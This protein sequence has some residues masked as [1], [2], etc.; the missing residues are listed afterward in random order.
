MDKT[1]GQQM[2]FGGDYNP[3]QW[4]ENSWESDI[5]L[6][7]QAH[8][9]SAT[10]NVFSWA[11]LEPAEGQF[12]FTKL[13][14]IIKL[15]T[16]YNFKIVLATATAAL[17]AW[18]VRQYP[19]V[20][21]VN[22]NG[23]QQQHGKRHNACP[24]NPDSQRLASQLVTQLAERFA[25][26][27]NL[28]Y[29]HIS[30]E[31][32]GLCYCDNCAQA[33]RDWLQVR[34]GDIDTLNSAWNSH[35]WSHTYTDWIDILPPMR[36]TDLFSN[37]KP[38]LGGAALD[39]QRFQ[40]DSLLANYTMERDIIRQFDATTPMT[41][42]L[43]GSQKD[44][45]Y[46]KWAPEMDIISWDNYPSYDT[47]A[48]F[49]AMQHDLMFGLKQKPFLLMEQTPNQQNW[50]PFNALKKPGEV[51]M[52]SFQAIAHGANSVQFFQLKQSL[53]GAEKF[54]G[55]I[56]PHSGQTTGRI[57]KEIAQLGTDF[58]QLPASLLDT[59]KKAQVALVFDWD[60]YWG[61]ENSIGPTTKLDY[62]QMV[63]R[64]YALFYQAGIAVDLI[65]TD[66]A[67]I[68]Y[69][70]VLAP[71][72]YAANAQFTAKVS[73]YVAHGGQFVTTTMAGLTDDHDHIIPGGYPGAFREVLGLTFDE[74]D[75]LPNEQTV[76]LVDQQAN[77]LGTGT[78]LC[79]LIQVS[80]AE[81]LAYYDDSV[82]YQGTP[83]VTVNHFGAGKAYYIGTEPD[84]DFLNKL[85]INLIPLTQIQEQHNPH[86]EITTRETTDEAFHFVINTTDQTQPT[87]N[88]YPG[89]VDLLSGQTYSEQLTL[90]PFAVLI[91][92]VKKS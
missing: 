14:K 65:S 25:N 29:W 49:T 19:A 72:L 33:F 8:I 13:K 43:M 32:G 27:P 41:T 11:L 40:S 3:E 51:R 58:Q 35:F 73:E 53:S 37:G 6:L 22:P 9:N 50:Q 26:L 55:A 66:M 88:P 30:N 28:A 7:Q 86:V 17:P 61:L 87:I 89:Q 78:T 62:V 24:N 52:F 1:L 31:Y 81:P 34:Y 15:L 36:T 79:D 57:F 42:N 12:D 16:K 80:T 82:F 76:V 92:R 63:H 4:P 75:A 68:D 38:V 69:D 21:R 60:S 59:S 56:I 46:F 84:S 2:L 5:Q 18:L 39:Y 77:A 45:D 91:F 10:I 54:H 67:L 48:S 70:L 47:P 85:L 64:Y 44:L 71:K 23:I 74:T 90:D 83:A 20:G